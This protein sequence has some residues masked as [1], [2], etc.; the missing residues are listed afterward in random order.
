MYFKADMLHVNRDIIKLHSAASGQWSLLT[1]KENSCESLES[2]FTSTSSIALEL[3]PSLYSCPAVSHSQ[4]S[5]WIIVFK[6]NSN[7]VSPCLEPA[8]IFPLYLDY[9][10]GSFQLYKINVALPTFP[11]SSHTTTLDPEVLPFFL[12]LVCDQTECMC[13]PQN[14]YVVVLSP[15]MMVLGGGVFGLDEVTGLVS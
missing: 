1:I 14:S 8:D 9:N 6:A 7:H 15:N 12:I 2:S 3:V 10:S 13:L 4:P 11:T 5:I